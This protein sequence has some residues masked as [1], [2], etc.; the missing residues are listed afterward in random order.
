MKKKLFGVISAAVL[1]LVFRSV[2]GIY[3]WFTSADEQ[4]NHFSAG[5][6]DVD[7]EED[8]PDPEIKPGE[9]VKKEVDFTNTGTVPCYV[10]ARYFFSD[11]EAEQNA[12]VELNEEMWSI[13]ED[14]YYYYA[15]AIN[16]GDKTAPFVKAVQFPEQGGLPSGFDL[17]IYTETVQSENHATP[18][19]AFAHLQR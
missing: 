15:K 10:R 8:F 19:E 5:H 4:V 7:I 12:V 6:N 1:L 13:E 9:K 16:P 14:G 3:G 18:Q 17:D 2:S 11:G